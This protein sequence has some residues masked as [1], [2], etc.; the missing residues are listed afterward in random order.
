MARRHCMSGGMMNG[1]KLLPSSPPSRGGGIY[2]LALECLVRYQKAAVAEDCS[3]G[4]ARARGRAREDSAAERAAT[5]V[6]R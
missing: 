2:T 3:R 4:S 5:A 1:N 6:C